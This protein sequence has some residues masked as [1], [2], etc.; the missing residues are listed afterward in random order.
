MISFNWSLA[1]YEFIL[2]A[3]CCCLPYHDSAIIN[4]CENKNPLSCEVW[5]VIRFLDAKK[6]VVFTKFIINCVK[7][8]GLQ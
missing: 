6:I 5:S 3:V 2:T 8:M 7:R 4:D 1:S